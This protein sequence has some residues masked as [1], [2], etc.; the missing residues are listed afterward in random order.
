MTLEAFLYRDDKQGIDWIVSSEWPREDI[1]GTPK[2]G[3]ILFD[4][5]TA[6]DST[7]QVAA[8][9]FILDRRLGQL[10]KVPDGWYIIAAGNRTQ[11][12]A[13]A[14]TM[15]SALAN[16]FC[17]IEVGANSTSWLE[18]ALKNNIDPMVTGFIRF[19]PQKLFSMEGNKER[20]WP[21][22]RSWERVSM[23]LIAAKRKSLEM[24]LQHI[25]IEGLVGEST[26]IEFM[27][28]MEWS[29]KIPDVAK[30]LAGT[31]KVSVPERSDQRYAMVSA[32]VYHV[33][34]HEKPVEILN[35]LFNIM[36]KFPN[37][38]IQL[39]YHDITLVMESDNKYDFIE[40]L[41]DHEKT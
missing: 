30:M 18:W 21:S 24:D 31:S 9:E 4:E 39:I 33:R 22:P 11:D 5:I 26:A 38:W 19:M 15:S 40:S 3:I 34:Q 35:G 27:A 12:A 36:L 20:G 16:R 23:E 7:L 41:M 37:D 10:Y 25:L 2:K 32:L 17:H 13:V 14:R 8:Y 28:F 1:E 29:G 6:A